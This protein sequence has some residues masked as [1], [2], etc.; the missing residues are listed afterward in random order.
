MM[1]ATDVPVFEHTIHTTNEWIGELDEELGRQD[2]HQAYRILRAVLIALRDRLPVDEATD[3]GAQLP[4]LVRGFYYE[5]WNPSKTP[6]K[7][8]SLQAFLDHISENLQEMAD[9]DPEDAAR[10]VFGLLSRH[11]TPGEI[12]HVKSNLPA[13]V[14]RIWP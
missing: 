13:G 11:V 8:R 10:A 7:E 3:L 12:E 5:G 9:G 2:R 6:T 4:M 14:R 1:T